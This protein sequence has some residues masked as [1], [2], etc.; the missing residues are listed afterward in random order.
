ML[1]AVLRRHASGPQSVQRTWPVEGI[2]LALR[3][4]LH[5]A[6]RVA[7]RRK[8]CSPKGPERSET[9]AT[10][11]LRCTIEYLSCT[12]Q[13]SRSRALL[14]APEFDAGVANAPR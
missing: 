3:V 4:A 7:A 1:P 8:V 5:V 11:E 10:L 12:Q 2:V 13:R 14:W 9:R 6:L